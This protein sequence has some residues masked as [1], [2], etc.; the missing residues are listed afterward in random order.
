MM[1]NYEMIPLI[2]L[3]QNYSYINKQLLKKLQKL[4]GGDFLSNLTIV[5]IGV[6]VCIIYHVGD[7]NGFQILSHYNALTTSPRFGQAPSSS[8]MSAIS[9]KAKE[10]NEMLLKFNEA[11]T[12]YNFVMSAEKAQEKINETYPGVV[13]DSDS[14]MTHINDVKTANK[15]YHASQ[16]GVNPNYY[17]MKD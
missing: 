9:T 6:I 14:P 3:N 10:F 17:G 7:V 1:A 5:G 13:I 4:W 16:V 8:Q 11:K 2:Y 15:I 12:Y